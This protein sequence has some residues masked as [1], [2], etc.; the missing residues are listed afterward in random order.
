MKMSKRRMRF[1]TWC[2]KD[3]EDTRLIVYNFKDSEGKMHYFTSEDTM[4]YSWLGRVRNAWIEK[5]VDCKNEFQDAWVA[6]L[7]E[8]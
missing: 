5:I 8:D 3:P 6:Y 7:Y 4:P 1:G 2:K